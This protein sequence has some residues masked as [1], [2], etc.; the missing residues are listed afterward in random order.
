[1]NRRTFLG[2]VGTS[3]AAG[4]AGCNAYGKS[5]DPVGEERTIDSDESD[6][7][8]A[9]FE[10][11]VTDIRD[12]YGTK[13]IWGMA[14]SGPSDAIEFHAAWTATVDQPSGAES[15]HLLALYRLPP[16]PEGTESL[17]VWLWSGVNSDETAAVRR[18]ETGISLPTDDASL[19]I[20]SPAGD[21]DASSETEYQV[22]SGRLDAVTLGTTMPLTSGSIGIAE[23]T[24]IGDGGAYYPYWEGNS[25]VRQSL[26]ATT[27][28]RSTN[29]TPFAIEWSFGAQ[30]EE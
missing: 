30:T 25:D 9:E 29:D 28:I 13:G 21:I 4:S 5:A 7:S 19:K 10:T 11:Y 8:A 23:E 22:K 3:V 20:Y 6:L 26:A 16:G 1:M 17:Q 14:E 2:V 27:E 24:H 12:R 18:L 15:D